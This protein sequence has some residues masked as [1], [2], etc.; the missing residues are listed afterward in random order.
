MLRV[1][2]YVLAQSDI[3]TCLLTTCRLTQKAFLAG[4]RVFI[5]AQDET[6]AL[7]CDEW[8]WTF[9]PD[10]FLPHHCLGDGDFIDAPILIG[11]DTPP[12]AD[13]VLLNLSLRQPKGLA[14]FTRVLEL[15]TDEQQSKQQGRLRWQYYKQQGYNLEKHDL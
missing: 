4:Q 6:Q 10:S 7:L 5:Q 15:I 13:G 1:D 3:D 9:K 12:Q 2:F 11:L 14:Q 8:L